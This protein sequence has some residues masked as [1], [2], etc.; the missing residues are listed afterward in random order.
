M[1]LKSIVVPLADSNNQPK[2]KIGSTKDEK[3]VSIFV[4][5][6]TKSQLI[7]YA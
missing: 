4:I 3:L 7:F 6:R 2:M 1:I 5:N